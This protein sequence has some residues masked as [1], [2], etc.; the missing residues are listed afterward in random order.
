[1]KNL[2]LED[3]AYFRLVIHTIFGLLRGVNVTIE[4][5]NSNCRMNYHETVLSFIND[6]KLISELRFWRSPWLF[7]YVKLENDDESTWSI[8][9]RTLNNPFNWSFNQFKSQS[10]PIIVSEKT[11]TDLKARKTT[12]RKII[13]EK[14]RTRNST[15]NVSQIYIVSERTYVTHN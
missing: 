11:P 13:I 2:S 4:H 6:R 5:I 3:C 12:T 14:T 8:E 7:A 15:Q 1:M 9:L 10:K